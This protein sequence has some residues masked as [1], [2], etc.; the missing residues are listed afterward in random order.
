M[1][2][3]ALAAASLVLLT[4]AACSS[5]VDDTSESGDAV[6]S[7]S[8]GLKATLE[9]SEGTLNDDKCTITRNDVSVEGISPDAAVRINQVLEDL[10]HQAFEDRDCSA[11]YEFNSTMTVKTN[12]NGYLSIEQVANGFGEGQ[13]HDEHILRGYNFDLRTGA[14]LR[15]KD[16]ITNGAITKAIP[17]CDDTLQQ[18]VREGGESDMTFAQQCT[19]ELMELYGTASFTF[20]RSGIRIHPGLGHALFPIELD[21]ALIPWTQIDKNL[22]SVGIAVMRATR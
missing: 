17:I 6:S 10:Q 11:E 21:G 18:A 12:A 22:T 5:T 2:S 3:F 1:K 8:S 19:D 20:D 15:L 7:G 16:I 14:R 4:T 13:M 9:K